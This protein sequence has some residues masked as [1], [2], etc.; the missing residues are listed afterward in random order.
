MSLVKP[1]TPHLWFDTQ[2]REAAE[3]Y[4]SVFPESRIDYSLVLPDTPSGD[5]DV[6]AFTLWGQPFMAIS[7]GPVFKPNPSVSF[8]VRFDPSRD[9]QA[10]EKLDALWAALAV[11]GTVLMPLD[12]YPWSERYGWIQDRFGISWQL[13]LTKPEDEPRPPIMPSLM[14]V[15]P[16]CGKAEEAMRYYMSVFEG[17]APGVLARYPAGMAPDKEGTLMYADFTLSGQWF[18]VMDSAQA[19]AFGFNEALSFIV[20]CRDQK[21][22][23][24]YWERLSTVPEAEVCGWCKDQFGVSWQIDLALMD[25]VMASGDKNAIARVTK[26]FLDMSKLDAAVLEAAAKGD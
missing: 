13:T 26:A 20:R 12:G 2:A 14:F 6:M 11:D 18:A 21:E 9:A 22:I 3:F 8:F 19:H 5:C 24:Y 15:G 7:A 23:D 16:A 10:R 1:I 25:E 4:C 17:S